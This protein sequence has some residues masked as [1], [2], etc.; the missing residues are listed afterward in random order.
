MPFQRMPWPIAILMSALFVLPFSPQVLAQPPA[1]DTRRVIRLRSRVFT[2]PEGV[3]DPA[4]DE[5]IR[6]VAAS[7]GQWIQLILRLSEVPTPSTW[8]Q[9]AA[10]GI[11]QVS[12]LGDGNFIVRMTLPPQSRATLV[13]NLR[14]AGGVALTPL[15]PPDKISP[16]VTRGH[17]EEWA[18]DRTSDLLKVVVL[19]FPET[20]ASKV[21]TLLQLAHR[22]T[23]PPAALGPLAWGIQIHP[24]DAQPLSEFEEVHDIDVGPA[25]KLPLLNDA[26]WK[27]GVE[28]AQKIDLTASGSLYTQGLSG[29]GVRISTSETFLDH[30]DFWNHDAT[31]ARTTQRWI[32]S[33]APN[34]DPNGHGAMTA[35]IALGNGFLSSARGGTSYQWR[36]VAPEALFDCGGSEDIVSRSF[37]QTFGA[38]DSNAAG[39]DDR[40]RGDSGGDLR[41]QVW[42][43]ANQGIHSQYGIQVGYYSVYAPAKNSIA[44]ANLSA[45]TLRWMFSS[46]G[47]TW[48]GR[49]KPDLS[50]PGTKEGFP[51]EKSQLL[52]DIDYVKLN[53]NS[54]AAMTWS[55]NGLAWTGG[56]GQSDIDG[57]WWTQ[58]NVGPISQLTG[59]TEALHVPLLRTGREMIGTLRQPDGAT[60]L[61]VNGGGQDTLEI[62]YRVEEDLLWRPGQATFSWTAD[63]YNYV[64]FDVTFDLVA[65]GAWHTAIV[66]VGAETGWQMNGINLIRIGF[67]GPAMLRAGPVEKYA[68]AGGSSAAAPM[69]SGAIALLMDQMVQK[70][71]VVL[72]Q[73]TVN[74]PFWFGAPGT[75]VPLPS[76]FKALLIHGAQDLAYQPHADE[77]N[78][79]DTQA[80]TIYHNGPDLVTGYGSIDIA[81]SARVVAAHSTLQP[82][83]VERSISN[84]ASHTYTIT[85]PPSPRAP[86]KVTL[87]WDD[88]SANP[89]FDEVA[90]H[91]VNDLDLTLKDPNGNTHYPYSID[92]P[93]SPSVPPPDPNSDYPS[94]VEPE[95]VLAANIHPARQDK[96]NKLDNV[97]QVFVP[98]PQP[99]VWT[100]QVR[101]AQLW[102]PPQKYSLVLRTPPLPSTRLNGGK[103]VFSSDRVMPTQLYV[104]QVDSSSPPVQVTSGSIGARHP[105]WSPNGKYIAYVTGD[106][107][108]GNNTSNQVDVLTFI[109]ESGA[110]KLTVYAPSIGASSLG[111]PQWSNDGR[112]IVVTYWYSWGARGLAR[113]TFPAPYQFVAPTV[114]TLVAPGGNLNPAEAVFSRDGNFVYFTADSGAGPSQLYRIPVAG[115]AVSPI[116][117][118]GAQLRR[119][120]APSISPDGTQLLYNS[121]MWR[122]DPAYQDEELLEL[123]LLTGVIR[124]ITAEPGNQY[125]WFGR[126]GAGEMVMQSN[127]TPS[128][129]TDIFLEENGVRIP[130]DIGDPSNTWNDSAPDWWKPPCGGGTVLWA[131][132]EAVGC[133]FTSW[134]PEQKS[135]C[136]AWTPLVATGNGSC[137]ICLD[138]QWVAPVLSGTW[139]GLTEGVNVSTAVPADLSCRGCM[140]PPAQMAGWWPLDETSGTIAADRSPSAANGT[141]AGSPTPVPGLVQAGLK[142]NGA[143]AYV[144]V[145]PSASLNAGIGNLSIDAWV[146]I[147]NAAD[148]T[149]VRVIVEK[150]QLSPLRGYSLFLY[151]GGDIGLQLADGLGSQWSNYLAGVKVPS[152]SNWHLVAVTV[153]RAN[154][155]GGHFYLDGLPAGASFNPTGRQGTLSNTAP[156]RIGSVTQSIGGGSFFKGSLDEVELYLRALTPYEILMLHLAGPCGKCK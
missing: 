33:C 42:A 147:D 16:R 118:N 131:S 77:E 6:R 55:F 88:K 49:I 130:L 149:G 48:D 2:A 34:T 141:Y 15:L 52:V 23:E 109:T 135:I 148:L 100:V 143:G 60:L 53:L 68:G 93:Y 30:D 7:G 140:R 72:G 146:K 81:E 80:K 123:G 98:N 51:E 28:E 29:K 43:V 4:V 106:F 41:P 66:P 101:G 40:I 156:L 76:T 92:Q 136:G 9:L 99:G 13:Q 79:P 63:R 26:R 108:V 104:K 1:P 154:T 125:G 84:G 138:E 137:S 58:S 134:G 124:R 54:S 145:A 56:W 78:N 38:Y 62:R 128:A 107:I 111:Y 132:G 12:F 133:K 65:D 32:G 126:N 110:P 3:V 144:Q 103:V 35:G 153:D 127:V 105:R 74:S 155:Q 117:G 120:Y 75:G 10:N 50:A 59:P 91:L 64:F 14:A 69:V 151:N 152:D 113:L 19:F 95:P 21:R 45:A 22:G 24:A 27:T 36:G 67:G 94:V 39:I 121:E 115:G 129:K 11:A 61:S 73:R 44:V 119:A 102:V 46:I 142:L 57:T 116:F 97:E 89:L 5:R 37:V 122:D 20:P 17:Y 85:V 96:L 18:Y 90:P 70:F 47:P 83:V 25:P 71:G 112:N 82:S 87:A 86:L 31:G 114:T 150:R 8:Q 139:A